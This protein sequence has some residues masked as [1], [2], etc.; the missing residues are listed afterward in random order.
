MMENAVF[1]LRAMQENLALHQ[2]CLLAQCSGMRVAVLEGLQCVDSGLPVDTY[3]SVSFVGKPWPVPEATLAVVLR[4][5]NGHPFA[6]RVLP[7]PDAA[8]VQEALRQGGMVCAEEERAMW[9]AL[10][11]VADEPPPA[12]LSIY[13]VRSQAMLRDYASVVAANWEPPDLWSLTY[14]DLVAQAAL[15]A[16]SPLRLLVGY[17]EGRPVSAAECCIGED[18][19]AGVYCIATRRAWRRRGYGR[20]MTVAALLAARRAGCSLAVLQASTQGAGLYARLGFQ[21]LGPVL[22]F[23]PAASSHHPSK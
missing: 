18:G 20:A 9:C 19:C 2:R 12:S 4:W 14:F 16:K 13:P 15:H 5:F 8:A 10:E 7:G 23:Q 6:W 22:E 1:M 17:A 21:D 11:A 3:S